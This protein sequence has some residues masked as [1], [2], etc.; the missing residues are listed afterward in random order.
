MFEGE[1]FISLVVYSISP[2]NILGKI[3]Y[4]KR[5]SQMSNKSNN[6]FF[7]CYRQRWDNQS[8]TYPS[9]CLSGKSGQLKPAHCIKKLWNGFFKWYHCQSQPHCLT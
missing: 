2:L 3:K 1:N 5:W 8:L 6:V 7:G 9:P 4:L